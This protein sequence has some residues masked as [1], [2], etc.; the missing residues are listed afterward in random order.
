M[1]N[2]S[3]L[4]LFL[5]FYINWH[6]TENFWKVIV[7]LKYIFKHEKKN[8][9]RGKRDNPHMYNVS[10]LELI[11]SKETGYETI[12]L[13]R[14]IFVSFQKSDKSTVQVCRFCFVWLK[15]TIILYR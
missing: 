6:I 5:K 12:S 11:S 9:L 7:C 10:S 15:D 14:L 3:E 13:H 8:K 1:K 4:L 2:I